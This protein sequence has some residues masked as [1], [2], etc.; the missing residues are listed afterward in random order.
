MDL[1]GDAFFNGGVR[2][3]QNRSGYRFSIDAVLLAN[4]IDDLKPGDR[5]L[6]LGTGCGI[7][8]LM[9]AF[10]YPQTRIYGVEVQEE[11]AEISVRN[12]MENRMEHQIDMLCMDMKSLM[13]GMVSGS[14]DYVVT[15]PPYR[16]Y[17]SGRLNPNHQRAAARHEIHITLDELLATAGRMLNP[18]GG[19]AAVYVAERL[20]DMMAGMRSAGIEPKK[21][22][23]V[24]SREN[25]EAKLILIKGTK[26]G[27][28]GLSIGPPLVI[29][30][31]GGTYTD[32]V[33]QMFEP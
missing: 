31:E 24:Y 15:N 13:P 11:L 22:R 1:T 10:R 32:E 28:P 33:K 26:G 23:L 16:K 7:I 5:V 8:A 2:V 25:Q 4:F 6:D 12:V 9:L 20:T 19:F 21:L 27:R 18:F 30:Q 3:C 14:M 29:Y 17:R